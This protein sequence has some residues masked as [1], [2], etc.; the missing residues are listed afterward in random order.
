[1]WQAYPYGQEPKNNLNRRI[2]YLVSTLGSERKVE[3]YFDK[4]FSKIK[5]TL[6]N[7]VRDQ[8]T[9]QLMQQEITSFIVKPTFPNKSYVNGFRNL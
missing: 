4:S 8:M 2:E 1:M 5:E 3:Q 6:Q 7:S 9:V